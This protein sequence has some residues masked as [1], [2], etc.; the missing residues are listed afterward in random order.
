M[1][2]NGLTFILMLFC[3][4]GNIPDAGAQSWLEQ[5][6]KRA[7]NAAKRKVERKVDEK[8]NKALD[9]AFDKA[10]V[11][12]RKK[13]QV[14]KKGDDAPSI[15]APPDPET[16]ALD[17]ARW[18]ETAPYSSFK[19]GSR[20]VYTFYNGKGKE[21]GYNRQEIV[22]YSSTK[23]SVTAVVAGEH[24]DQKGNVQTSGT[25][26]LRY[27][28]GNFQA[29]LLDML[30]PQG[31]ENIDMEAEMSGRE[32]TIPSQLTPGQVLPDAQAVIKIKM[33]PGQEAL[34]LPPLTFRVFDRRAIQAES[35]K[36]PAGEFVCFRIVQT[37]E[38]DYP[39]IGKQFSTSI[40][41]IGKGIGTIKCEGYDAKG[42][43]VSTMLLTKFEE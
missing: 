7:E 37:L 31:L 19:K 15:A 8:V 16:P 35:L 43:L 36:T 42:R 32:M 6:G 40:T 41:W 22:E 23:N 27:W 2:T 4:L 20:L 3:A 13:E 24:V 30:S 39:I 34:E 12:T 29:D 10:E 11:Q 17:P 26:S 18:N 14:G 1:K 5:L 38:A 33:K 28:N 21:Q 9:G 25:V